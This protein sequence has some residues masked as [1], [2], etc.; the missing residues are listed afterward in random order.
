MKPLKYYLRIDQRLIMMGLGFGVGIAAGLAAVVLNRSISGLEEV[1][2]VFRTFWWAPLI[3]GLGAAASWFVLTRVIRDTP[4]H[5]VPEVIYS[6]SK[7]GGRLRFRSSFSRLISSCLTIGSGGSAGPEAPIVMSGAALGSTLARLMSLNERQRIILVGCGAAGAIASI[8]N[9]PIAGMVFAL[10]VIL[11]EWRDVNIGP[12]AISSV[13]GVMV[14]RGLSGN[15][16]PFSH[17]S[18][19]L[20]PQI[21]LA[22]AILAVLTALVSVSLTRS[23]SL[24]A[25][26][27][28]KVPGKG[29]L[30]A[31]LGGLGVGLLGM[32]LPTVLGEG[33]LETK[34]MINGGFRGSLLLIGILLAAKILAT[35]LT[36]GSGGSGGIFAPAL[37]IGAV[38][39]LAFHGMLTFFWP[40]VVW[41][42]SGLFALLGMA[43][44]IG[45]VLQAPL[46]A[47]FLV[48]EI[49]GG[50]DLILPLLVVSVLSSAV[51]R[52]I[53][54]ASIYLKELVARGQLLRPGTDARVLSDLQIRELLEKDCRTVFENQNL[55]EL[56]EI[57]KH[58]HRNYFPVL[59]HRDGSFIGMLHLDGIRE[60]LFD[61]GLY[62]AVLVDDMMHPDPPRVSPTDAL[63]E[64]LDRMDRMRVFSLPV[65][66]DGRF[67]G[68]ISKA[69]LLDQYRR[70]L[71]VQT[72]D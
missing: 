52:Q 13:A 33:Y 26:W 41:S 40:S 50:Y 43:G 47:F 54:P 61:P 63:P 44:L 67:L 21:V 60:Y 65:V 49:T 58:S 62:E 30:R 72:L 12:I 64:V 3:P 29:V 71:S 48:V 7:R 45:G 27:W 38:S 11:G 2:M 14:C 5:G 32:V 22:S 19:E 46:T 39:G 37:T 25:R 66:E 6:V 36:L 15:Q 23:I 4:G 68:M 56:V 51:S 31:G 10:E 57:V 59:D 20:S 35:S 28:K 34:E 70:E 53:E 69:T 18:F 42:T 1:L 24:S 16:I 9:A 8:F 17:E 55:G